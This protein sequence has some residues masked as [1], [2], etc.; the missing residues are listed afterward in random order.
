MTQKRILIVDDDAD[1]REGLG[2][3]LRRRGY[4]VELA[5][6]A[7]EA[8]EKVRATPYDMALIDVVMPNGDGIACLNRILDAAP[9]TL[10]MLMTGFAVHARLD[11][12]LEQG[13]AFVIRKPIEIPKL[14]A[15][16]KALLDCPVALVAHRDRIVAR[17]I[18]CALER[19]LFSVITAT[20]PDQVNQALQAREPD[21]IAMDLELADQAPRGFMKHL[22]RAAGNR[23]LVLFNARSDRK[24]VWSGLGARSRLVPPAGNKELIA[25]IRHLWEDTQHQSTA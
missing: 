20:A 12:G 24:H 7:A 16:L 15:A 21:L 8:L 6:G 1:F 11:E 13:A 10:I 17:S 5:C 19:S 3:V 2:A 4:I 23:P 9:N 22:V 25:E 18:K 14:L